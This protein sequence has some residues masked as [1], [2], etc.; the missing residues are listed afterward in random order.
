M[1]GDKTPALLQEM[2]SFT[3][4]PA[5][6]YLRSIALNVTVARL[7]INR[8]QQASKATD[9]LGLIIAPTPRARVASQKQAR[10]ST[11]AK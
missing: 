8:W 6:D 9:N 7:S 2:H 3:T 4:L 11:K 10:S 1:M 5:R